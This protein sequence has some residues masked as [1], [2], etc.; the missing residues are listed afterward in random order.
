MPAIEDI[1]LDAFPLRATDKIRY[2]DTDRQ[3]HVNNAVFATFF[4]TGRVEILWDPTAPLADAGSSFVIA[5]LSIDFRAEIRW[6]GEVIIGTRVGK[7]GRSS[8]ALDQAI[9]QGDRCVASAETVIVM[10]DEA[11]HRSK[12]LPAAAIERLKT[13]AAGAR[14]V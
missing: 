14:A 5:R 9:F 10:I 13:L 12:P 8:V 2:G 7:I 1:A 3:G 11:T 6:P 4:E